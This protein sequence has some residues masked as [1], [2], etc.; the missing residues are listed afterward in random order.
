MLP[1]STRAVAV[2]ALVTVSNLPFAFGGIPFSRC[3]GRSAKVPFRRS[4]VW[5]RQFQRRPAPVQHVAVDCLYPGTPGWLP[6]SRS[7]PQA[8]STG[9]HTEYSVP[10]EYSYSYSYHH[11]YSYSSVASSSCA[12]VH[13]SHFSR[14]FP[15]PFQPPHATLDPL[16]AR[17][18]VRHKLG[19]RQ[20]L[21]LVV[22]PHNPLAAAA[23]L[24]HVRL[25]GPLPVLQRLHARHQLHELGTEARIGHGHVPDG[26]IQARGR[27]GKRARIAQDGGSDGVG[28]ELRRGDTG[29]R[30]LEERGIGLVWGA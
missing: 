17:L 29:R 26:G 23:E 11:S 24:R 5:R 12:H 7:R 30:C 16:E 21:P 18:D 2:A 13:S 19:R 3:T 6:A 25:H 8:V 28:V 15:L 10:V 27:R 4:A 20:G 9:T 14:L 1:S 22:L